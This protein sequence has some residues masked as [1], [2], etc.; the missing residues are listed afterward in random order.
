MDGI[1]CYTLENIRDASELNKCIKPVVA[2]K[3]YGYEETLTPLI[4]GACLHAM[5]ENVKKFNVDNIRVAKVLGGSIDDSSVVHGLILHRRCE[6]SVHKV[7][8]AKVACY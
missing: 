1:P 5:P 7:L 3:H 6:T 4:T 8:E 2:A